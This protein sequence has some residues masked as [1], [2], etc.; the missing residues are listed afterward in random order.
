MS[1][2][3][4]NKPV[5]CEW[6]L[7]LSLAEAQDMATFAKAALGLGQSVALTTQAAAARGDQREMTAMRSGLRL[8]S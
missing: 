5:F 3:R 2:L 6:P 1:S 4:A 7:G 8:T